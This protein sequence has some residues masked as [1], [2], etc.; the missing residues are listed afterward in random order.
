MDQAGAVRLGRQRS[1]DKHTGRYATQYVRAANI[2]PAGLDLSDLLE[3]DFTP[4]ERRIFALADGDILLTEASGSAAHVGRAALWRGEI[5]DCCYQNTV[6]RFRPHL[7]LPEYALM[8]FRHYAA[9][10]IFARAARGVGIQHLGASRFAALHFPLPPQDEQRRITDV[11]DRRLQEI[12][13]AEELLRSALGRL[14]EQ[15]RETLAAAAAGELAEQHTEQAGDERPRS[16]ASAGSGAPQGSLFDAFEPTPEDEDEEISSEPLPPGWRWVRVAAAGNVTLGRQ[17]APQHQHGLHMRPYLRVANVF[18]DRIDTSDILEMNFTPE[19]AEVYTL[20]AGDI[21]LNE[22][23]SPELVGRPAMYRNEIPGACFQNTLIRFRAGDATDP[24]YALLIF[25]HYLHSGVFRRIARWSTNIAHLGLERF[26][27]LPFPLPPL[28]EQQR[29]VAQTRCRLAAIAAQIQAVEASISRL[30]EMETEL[31]AAAVAGEL[32]EQDPTDEPAAALIDRLGP[33]P[34]EPLPAND[35]DEGKETA[36]VPAKRTSASRRQGPNS[37]LAAVLREAGRPLKLPE[38]FGQAG[39]D[40]DEPEHVE[41]FYLAL[42]S[43]LG[44]AIQQVGDA[45]ENAELEA[46]DAAR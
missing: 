42:R 43:Q 27:A 3:M 45:I 32:V 41:L 1:P 26:R 14:G 4:R 35:A 2:T 46:V 19:E 30:P 25:R 15:M 16:S 12:R 29:I 39:F 6:I 5:D 10:G 40:R 22:G 7:A 24:D 11:A 31:L 20:E 21:L 23:Q 37:D 38:L 13:E 8:V 17:R 44:S 9:S 28:E 36:P 33:P 18:E 34:S